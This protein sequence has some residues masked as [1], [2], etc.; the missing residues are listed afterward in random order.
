MPRCLQC[1]A[2]HPP[3]AK[4]CAECGA[5]LMPSVDVPGSPP[6][7]V[8]AQH[9]PMREPTPAAPEPPAMPSHRA[10]NW[11]TEPP[12]GSV[13]RDPELEV[14]VERLRRQDHRRRRRRLGVFAC[15]VLI[16]LGAAV[17]GFGAIRWMHEPSEVSPLGLSTPQGTSEASPPTEAAI[18]PPTPDRV[19][20]FVVAE[21]RVS[22]AA[23]LPEPEPAPEPGQSRGRPVSTATAPR[24][25]RE[26]NAPS[27]R[28]APRTSRAAAALV[29]R[30]AARDPALGRV[31]V[32]VVV[33][34]ELLT[35]DVLTCTVRVHDAAETP[36]TDAFV[37]VHLSRPGG[38]GVE[39]ELNQV[40]PGIYRTQVPV[41]PRYGDLRVRVARA[42]RIVELP[43]PAP[44]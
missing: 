27:P 2:E 7:A 43:V 41:P 21:P 23:V 16:L 11:R 31:E 6:A 42:D 33:A 29:P 39:M 1:S 20:E 35:A 44:R 32:N 22:Y 15:V 12:A 30:V 17:L 3:A 18:A 37:A 36:I 34:T 24:V 25:D 13:T 8:R 28:V 14:L 26:R 10:P 19:A 38:A 5:R 9:T 40:K 4:F